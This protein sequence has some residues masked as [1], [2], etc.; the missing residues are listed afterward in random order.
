VAVLPDARDERG[1]RK[2]HSNF[3]KAGVDVRVPRQLQYFVEARSPGSSHNRNRSPD[4]FSPL[5]DRTTGNIQPLLVPSGAYQRWVS[6][7]GKRIVFGSA[8]GA[9]TP[10]RNE[11]SP[12][13]DR[14][15]HPHHSSDRRLAGVNRARC[16]RP[17]TNARDASRLSG[18]R[19][20]VPFSAM[21]NLRTPLP[22]YVVPSRPHL[23]VCGRSL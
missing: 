7:D 15:E 23:L 17:S 16:F 14:N 13:G 20:S 5:I 11:S 9:G 21:R 12:S 18:R 1:L 10:V 19:L 2:C 22:L 4:S 6:P 3:V 8:A